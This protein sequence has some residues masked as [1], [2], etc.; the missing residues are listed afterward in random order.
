MTG[1]LHWAY[2]LSHSMGTLIQWLSLSSQTYTKEI[3]EVAFPKQLS[4]SKAGQF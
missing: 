2:E 1:I 4:D 3:P